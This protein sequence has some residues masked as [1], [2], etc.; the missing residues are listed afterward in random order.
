MKYGDTKDCPIG[1]FDS[2][3]G[4]LTVL[5]QLQASLPNESFLYFGDTA[6]VPYGGRSPENLVALNRQILDWMSRCPVK[7]AVIACNTSSAWALEQL[8]H[9]YPFPI[10]GIILPVARAASSLGERIGV[11]ATQGTVSSDCYR[12]A[13]HEIDSTIDVVQMACPE[14]VP[15]IEQGKLEGVEVQRAIEERL[16]PLIEAKIDALIYGCTHYPHLELAIRRSMPSEIQLVDPALYIAKAVQQELR[17][18]RLHADA[19]SKQHTAFFVSGAPDDF[20]KLTRQLMNFSPRV[21]KITLAQPETVPI[22]T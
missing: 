15:L 10:L 21:Q 22:V 1:V 3:V 17:L 5:R 8:R 7:M 12:R 19:A 4:G 6:N 13:I 14:F 16:R 20:A 2:G 9:D 11:I 18:F